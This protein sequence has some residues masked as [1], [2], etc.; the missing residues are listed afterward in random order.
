MFSE[1]NTKG[2]AATTSNIRAS[3]ASTNSYIQTTFNYSLTRISKLERITFIPPGT[4]VSMDLYALCENELKDLPT[5]LF[6]PKD[7]TLNVKTAVI[8]NEGH[9]EWD[10]T[11]WEQ[12]KMPIL[13][14]KFTTETSPFLFRSFLSYST[15][16]KFST[17]AYVNNNFYVAQISEMPSSLF[18]AKAKK[19]K[20]PQNDWA[21]PNRFYVLKRIEF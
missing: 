16:E 10:S 17:E 21:L 12:K 18:S 3:S 14:A 6:S 13:I 4:T 2:E 8:M 7:T 15:D 5:N 1:T 20:T 11:V 19:E 9:P